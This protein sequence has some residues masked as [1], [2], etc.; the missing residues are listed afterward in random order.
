[1]YIPVNILTIVL[2]QGSTGRH[3]NTLS[4]SFTQLPREASKKQV[5]RRRISQDLS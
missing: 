3:R 5:S 4:G 2:E 1:M